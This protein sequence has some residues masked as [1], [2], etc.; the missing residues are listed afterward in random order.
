MDNRPQSI[1]PDFR[2]RRL[3]KDL[4][5]YDFP[6]PDRLLLFLRRT[7]IRIGVPSMPKDSRS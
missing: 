4:S 5:V 7:W 1:R 3:R 6:L 2:I